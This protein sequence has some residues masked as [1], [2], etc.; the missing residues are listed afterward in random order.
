[1]ILLDTHAL[2]WW[3]NGDS[4]L[5]GRAQKAIDETMKVDG[6]IFVSVIS[7]WEITLLTKKGRIE[8]STSIDTWVAHLSEVSGVEFVSITPDI[9][10]DSVMLPGEFHAD[11][12]DRM[13]V[14]TARKYKVP[15]VTADKKILS[16][17]Y[18]KTIW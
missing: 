7:L 18:V 1:M 16:Y 2:V 11:P 12:A 6:K 15:V 3:V 5:S 13:I 14:A 9:A 8:L 17:K 4:H 10:I